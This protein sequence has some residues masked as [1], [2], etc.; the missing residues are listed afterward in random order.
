MKKLSLVLEKWVLSNYQIIVTCPLTQRNNYY[1]QAIN[2]FAK[3]YKK[4]GFRA[5]KVPLEIVKKEVNP[6]Y[7]DMDAINDIIND[8]INQ[9]LE[10]HKDHKFI[11][12]PYELDRKNNENEVVL[13]YKLDVYP[14]VEVSNDNRKSARIEPM[15]IV[16]DDKEINEAVKWLQEQYA[17]YVDTD[18]IGHHTVDRLKAIYMNADSEEIFSKTLF[19]EHTDKHDGGFHNLEG[20]KTW[21]IIQLPYSQD[22]PEK[23]RYT[24]DNQ[25][26]HTLTLE[27][28]RTQTKQLP[29]LNDEKINEMFGN[30]N[31]TSLDDLHKRIREVLSEQKHSQTLIEHVNT[32]IDKVQWSFKI[33]VP[34]SMINKDYQ[35]RYESMTKKFGGIEKFEQAYLQLPNGKE[36]LEKKQMELKE[37]SKN[38]LI[39]FFLI[40]K[41]AELLSINDID[42][43]SDMDAES[44][45]YHHFNPSSSN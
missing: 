20:K 16:I 25:I 21:E 8:S 42:R 4:D 22:I 11:G 41:I 14:E 24:K 18:Q 17:T 35:S 29:E 40:N 9:L 45:L 33:V 28:L 6:L 15:S 26:P 38:S 23:L 30:E 13:N 37:I 10:E 12:E 19:V 7:F 39:K 31:I 32:Y 36:E 44:K 43:N 34:Q 5:G 1:Q 3:T 27:V 2:D